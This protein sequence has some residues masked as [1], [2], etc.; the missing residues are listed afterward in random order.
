ML[1]KNN[2]VEKTNNR[3]LFKED[4]LKNRHKEF[5]D[6]FI[7]FINNNSLNELSTEQKLYHYIFDVKSIP[8]CECGKE[9]SFIRFNKG[10]R[11]FCSNE[12]VNTSNIVKERIKKS[13]IEKYG[14]D[15]PMKHTETK[16]KVIKTNITKYGVDNP[17]KSEIIRQKIKTTV[18]LKYGVDNP[19]KSDLVVEKIRKINLDRYGFDNVSKSDVVKS[20]IVKTNLERYGV[21]NFSKTKEYKSIMK[22]FRK[23]RLKKQLIN[24]NSIL[25]EKL[26]NFNVLSHCNVCKIDFNISRDLLSLRNSRG[27]VVCTNCNPI[28]K[29]TVS[30]YEK[31]LYKILLNTGL[32]VETS[33]RGVVDNYELDIYIPSHNLAIE[34]NGLYWHSEL[35]KDKNY[36]LNK[37]IECQ[38]KDIKLLHIFEDEWLFKKDIVLSMINN[39]L[40]MSN[41]KIYA[42][43]CIIKEITTEECRKFLDENHIQGFIPSKLKLGL[44]REEELVSV[45]TFGSLRK[46]LGYN[47]KEGSYEMLRFCNKLNTNVVGGASKL[48]KYFVKNYHPKKIISYSDKRYFNGGLYEKLRFTKKHDTQPNYWYFKN[49]IRHHRFKYRKD[50]L[51]KQGYD[52]NK[53]EHQIMLERGIYRIYDCGNTFWVYDNIY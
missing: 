28:S 9:V 43:N 34:I 21:D 2:F 48:F 26:E 20:K 45:M 4:Y 41:H 32:S 40:N 8:K 27:H 39:N 52:P 11:Q 14:V 25:I 18:E 31:E 50:V 6:G 1:T 35:Y 37:T 7:F 44:Y 23:D 3:Y 36:H 17:L 30:S 13:F 24:N 53:T 22:K 15:N 10:Y 29:K 49:Y 5:Y 47:S 12:C 46:A 33:K 16:N 42:R 38:K 51:V 19:F